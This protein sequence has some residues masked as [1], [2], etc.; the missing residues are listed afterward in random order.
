M[1]KLSMKKNYTVYK[2][3]SP[4]GKTYVGMTS[5]PVEQRWGF[6][7]N[8]YSRNKRLFADIKKFGWENFSHL[9]VATNLTKEEAEALEEKT[10]KDCDS[11]NPNKGYNIAYGS[12]SRGLKASQETKDKQSIAKLGK[13]HVWTK[14]AKRKLSESKKGVVFTEEHK[15]KLSE[16]H[17]GK[18][19]PYAKR[20]LSDTE[21]KR[22][23]TARLG[24]SP[25]NKGVP[26]TDEQKRKITEARIGKN[27]GE[28]NP[29]S[30]RTQIVKDG[31]I[32]GVFNTRKDAAR[33]VGGNVFSL[34][35]ALK[36]GK[37]YLGYE[38]ITL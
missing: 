11:T 25:T 1:L 37:T 7:G 31:K 20:N 30:K 32:L 12:T 8:Q 22:R 26:M 29:S 19:Y 10:I 35:R 3:I 28:N 23:R 21:R 5:K 36:E 16:S 38:F 14:E 33:A 6:N 18:K 27:K 9:I 15:R 4:E 2:H 24:I 34:C 17:K 13:P